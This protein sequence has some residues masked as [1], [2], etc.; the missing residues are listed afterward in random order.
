MNPFLK[1]SLV[2]SFALSA[3]CADAATLKVPKQYP[4]IQDAID[5]AGA[6]DVIK[7]AA[8]LYE[9]DLDIIGQ[10]DLKIVGK[11][12]VRLR[13]PGVGS[14]IFVSNSDRVV[15]KNLR[16]E[17]HPSNAI[18]FSN[19]NEGQVLGCRISNSV[20]TSILFNNSNAAR[21]ENNKLT[22][23]GSYGIRVT[24]SQGAYISKNQVVRSTF[25]SISVLGDFHTIEDNTIQDSASN[26]IR[27]ASD[28]DS[29]TSCL[30]VGNTVNNSADDSIVL[31]ENA[32]SC[33]VIDNTISDSQADG[34]YLR[35]NGDG[36][37]LEGNK[38][39]KPAFAG[40]RLYADDVVMSNNQVKKAG[41]D[42]FVITF[43][44]DNGLFHKNV[45]K[46]A[47]EDGFRVSGAPHT[48]TQNM[49]KQSGEYDLNDTTLP[50]SNTY[51]NN[52]FET[53]P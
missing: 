6:H 53:L 15:L 28:L 52:Q 42:G 23:S 48:F 41:A 44:A 26:G 7:V 43:L 45:S 33:S 17:N 11:G 49:A 3:L 12:K 13:N 40:Y 5:A 47:T 21:I 4:T 10:D 2:A 25:T 18:Y 1:T 20:L 29:A 39:K 16:L 30:L 27:V 50:G 22:D 19:S 46:K 31:Y 51:V 9:E 35:Q 24:D 8:G 38:V 36:H 34:M 32:F 37:L 14:G